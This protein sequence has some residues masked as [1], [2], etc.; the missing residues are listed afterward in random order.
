MRGI[1]AVLTT[2]G[3]LAGLSACSR[4]TAARRP[5]PAPSVYAVDQTMR[6]QVTNAVDAGEGDVRVAALRRKV[7]A[8]PA[9]VEAR[10]ELASYYDQLGFRELA[11]EHYRSAAQHAPGRGD[12]HWKLARTLRGLGMRDEAISGLQKFVREQSAAD[13]EVMSWLGI[14]LDEAG[15]L[16]E[17]EA[18]HR[19]AKSLNG[20]VEFVYNNLGQNLMLQGRA[21]EA[22][23]EF[24]RAV[25][26]KPRSEIARNN[27]GLALAAASAKNP[28]AAREALKQWQS[29]ADPAAAHNN[30]AAALMEQGRYAEARKE[31]EAA[32][33]IRQG[34]LPALENLRLLSQ[35]DGGAVSYAVEPVSHSGWRRV[36]AALHRWFI[37]SEPVGAQR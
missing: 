9:N 1:V 23:A 22:L 13:I 35:L 25:E 8:E 15:R 18:S 30:L 24:R 7:V 37:S 6:R 32:L 29:V 26:L 14:L 20:S 33:N 19:A 4:H 21:E 3:A 12:A 34:F 11:A 28:E 36:T 2:A 10:M 17:A 31:L 5:A 16:V 27:M